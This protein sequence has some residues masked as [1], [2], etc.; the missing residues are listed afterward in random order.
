M[1]QKSDV[2]QIFF[3]FKAQAKNLLNT[4]IQTLRTDGG[5]E[6]KPIQK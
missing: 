2:A 6:Y 5:N 4:I 3:I 1:S